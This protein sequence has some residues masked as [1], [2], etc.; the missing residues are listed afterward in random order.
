MQSFGSAL[1]SLINDICE[2]EVEGPGVE[3]WD[4]D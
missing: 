1:I 3:G 2:E 4:W